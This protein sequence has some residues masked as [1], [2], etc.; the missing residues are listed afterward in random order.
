[1]RAGLARGFGLA[2]CLGST[3]ALLGACRAPRI[4][5]APRAYA[6]VPDVV[7]TVPGRPAPSVRD[8]VAGRMGAPLLPKEGGTVGG[9]YRRHVSEEAIAAIERAVRLRLEARRK[10]TRRCGPVEK[11][12]R[13]E[14]LKGNGDDMT[15]AGVDLGRLVS[16]I[17]KLMENA[18]R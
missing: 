8:S 18:G 17:K 5:A 10:P 15:G 2:L 12:G 4:A 3:C 13:S 6:T 1:M 9:P 7:G 14:R 16:G 11:A